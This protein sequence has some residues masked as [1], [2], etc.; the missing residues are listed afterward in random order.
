MTFDFLKK[1]AKYIVGLIILAIL[2]TLATVMAM[3]YSTNP[4]EK[5]EPFSNRYSTW[6]KELKTLKDKFQLGM[7]SGVLKFLPKQST[8]PSNQNLF[9]QPNVT[10][11]PTRRKRGCTYV[12]MQ[13]A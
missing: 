9:V 13:Y 2:I 6:S 3:A 1:Y 8:C 4:T 12:E 7:P 10:F 5:V 11:R